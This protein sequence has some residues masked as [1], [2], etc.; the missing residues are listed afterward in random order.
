[1]Q[2]QGQQT[3]QQIDD[4]RDVASMQ[5]DNLGALGEFREGADQ[6]EAQPTEL[7]E[8]D[9]DA[10]EAENQTMLDALQDEDV[11][12]LLPEEAKASLRDADTLIAK[13]EQYE[14]IV[15]A[16]RVCVVGSKGT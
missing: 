3:A 6:L 4:A 12:A 10:M 9:P 15:E 5:T 7:G 8:L 2:Q 14:E 13:A 16:G 1:M 11:Q